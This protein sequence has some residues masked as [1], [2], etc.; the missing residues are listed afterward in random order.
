[1]G[2][3]WPLMPSTQDLAAREAEHPFAEMTCLRQL[4]TSSTFHPTQKSAA[5]ALRFL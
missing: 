2:R 3:D 4:V 1:M 5:C